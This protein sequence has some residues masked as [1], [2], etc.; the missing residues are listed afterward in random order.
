MQG[1]QGGETSSGNNASNG[2]TQKL[3][4][5]EEAVEASTAPKPP[6][7]DLQELANRGLCA[8]LWRTAKPSQAVN[9][10]SPCVNAVASFTLCRALFPLSS[11]RLARQSACAKVLVFVLKQRLWGLPRDRSSMVCRVLGCQTVTSCRQAGATTTACK[12]C[13]EAP[14][15]SLHTALL[16]RPAW[17]SSSQW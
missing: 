13:R 7:D 17:L 4:K 12:P 10:H 6:S 2:T 16:C 11:C 3:E 5:A 15:G 9:C 14:H 1:E 8:P